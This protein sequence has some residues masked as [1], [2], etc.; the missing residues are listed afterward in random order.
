MFTGVPRSSPQR[1]LRTPPLRPDESFPGYLLRLT[2]ENSYDSLR[3]I[4]ERAG[5][6]VDP[7]M[8]K[9][10]CLWTT[11]PQITLLCEMAGLSQVEL[12]SLRERLVPDY[13]VR[14]KAPKICPSC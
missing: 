14:W 10:G 13:L 9:W 1:L 6:M 7:V 5:L 2:E 3:W 11:E 4:P 12:E 8:G